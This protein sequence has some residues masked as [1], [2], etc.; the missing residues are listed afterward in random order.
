MNKQYAVLIT[1]EGSVEAQ[2]D[3][4]RYIAETLPPDLVDEYLSNAEIE[5]LDEGGVDVKPVCIKN[6]RVTDLV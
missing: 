6:G 3:A 5:G 4:A 2:E 1:F